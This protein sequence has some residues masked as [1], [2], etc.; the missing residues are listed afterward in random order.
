MVGRVRRKH[1][2]LAFGDGESLSGRTCLI[3]FVEHVPEAQLLVSDPTRLE[4]VAP[5]DHTP[6]GRLTLDGNS[7]PKRTKL[8][9]MISPYACATMLATP[10]VKHTANMA[11]HVNEA[12]RQTAF[13]S[14]A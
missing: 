2:T 3:R 6:A 5:A 12:S 14:L 4:A 11:R 1:A 7:T 9:R 10:T 8:R 13:L